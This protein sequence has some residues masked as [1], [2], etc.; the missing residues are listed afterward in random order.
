MLYDGS[1]CIANPD[2][3]ELALFSDKPRRPCLLIYHDD[4]TGYVFPISTAKPSGTAHRAGEGWV[5]FARAYAVPLTQLSATGQVAACWDNGAFQ[6]LVR[7]KLLQRERDFLEGKELTQRPFDALRGV[8]AATPHPEAAPPA[9]PAAP[10]RDEFADYL[11]FD[12]D[13]DM[14]RRMK[15]EG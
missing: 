3:T 1:V 4:Q 12:L 14:R 15:G 6:K 9:P 8:K 5:I 7:E 2:G 10:V 11:K 13:R